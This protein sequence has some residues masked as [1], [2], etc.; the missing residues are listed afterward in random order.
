MREFISI[1]KQLA[2][3]KPQAIRQGLA[4]LALFLSLSPRVSHAAGKP[5]KT[6]QPEEDDYSS[7]PFTRYGDFN[8]QHDE[9]DDTSFLQ[10]G[11]FFGVSLGLG[12]QTITGNRGALYQGGFPVFDFK[13]HYWFDFSFALDLDIMSANHYFD[14]PTVYSSRTQVNI[15]RLGIDLRYYLDVKNLSAPISFANPFIIV[16]AGSYTKN[17]TRA[18]GSPGSSDTNLGMN[19]GFGLEF[20]LKP[21]KTYF[22]IE[23]KIHLVNFPDIDTSKFN[24]KPTNL[25][26]LSGMYLSITGNFLFTW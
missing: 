26:D 17:E 6:V 21:K 1:S 16:G 3:R 13:F 24:V 15:L 23:S 4:M 5:D 14:A 7:T 19:A 11:R 12:F 10:Y 8:M 9:D 22:Q 18:D 25:P 20:A 2:R